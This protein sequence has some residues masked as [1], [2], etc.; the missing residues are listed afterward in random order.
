MPRA[1][2]F[3]IKKKMGF[4][5]ISKMRLSPSLVELVIEPVSFVR[6]SSREDET[7]LECEM[8]RA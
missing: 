2:V 1:V 5:E 4:E 7:E 3:G 8:C 6:A